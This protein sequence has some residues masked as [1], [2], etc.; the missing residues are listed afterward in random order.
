MILTIVLAF[1]KPP[2]GDNPLDQARRV[3]A[4][5][6]LLDTGRAKNSSLAR[7]P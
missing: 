4:R 6:R 1:L 5:I 2:N 7:P 3:N